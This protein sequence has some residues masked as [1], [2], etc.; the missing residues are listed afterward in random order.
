MNVFTKLKAMLMYREAVQRANEAHTKRGTRYYVLPS[1]DGKLVVLDRYD[2][3]MLKR[4]HYMRSEVK[5]IDLVRDSFYFTPYSSGDGAMHPDEIERGKK[6][7]C[8]WWEH[9]KALQKK[10]RNSK[11]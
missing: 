1:E 3:K 6:R 2:L 8:I 10:I 7:V 9:H 11:K 4:R 5:V